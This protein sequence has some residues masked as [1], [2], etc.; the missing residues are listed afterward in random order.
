[1]PMLP[2]PERGINKLSNWAICEGISFCFPLALTEMGGALPPGFPWRDN[3]ICLLSTLVSLLLS[4]R[5]P[6]LP[7]AVV[8]ALHSFTLLTKVAL[9]LA[10]TH[11]ERSI[12]NQLLR[13]LWLSIVFVTF[14]HS[15]TSSGEP[16]KTEK[17]RDHRGS[18]TYTSRG[19]GPGHNRPRIIR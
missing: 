17:R 16:C 15:Q 8:A 19:V 6:V 11:H 5:C 2:G 4:A 9:S 12:P 10:A 3:H 1:M 7:V 18:Y 14:D 13:K